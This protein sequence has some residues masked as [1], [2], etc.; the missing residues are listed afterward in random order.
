MVILSTGDM[1]D[2]KVASLLADYDRD[3]ITNL[4]QPIIG[5][6]AL[7]V[8]FTFWSEAK[9]QRVISMSSHE[10]LLVRMKIATGEF[11]D[12]RKALEAVG[13]L[14]TRLEK[15]NG[16][17]IYHYELIPPK[18]PN[19]FFNDTL[20]YG[21][22]IQYLG[23]NEANRIKR[24]YETQEVSQV[25]D[26]ISSSFNDVF[27]P[28]F[29][30]AAFLLASTKV[31]KTIG[32]KKSKIDTEFSYEKFFASLAEVSQINQNALTKAEI[33]EIERLSTLYGVSEE[34]AAEKAANCYI[35]EN[36]KGKRLDVEQFNKDLRNEINYGLRNVKKTSKG[37]NN[38]F[39]EDGLAAKVKLYETASPEK[40]LSLLQNGTKPASADLNIIRSLAEDYHLENPVISVIIDFALQMNNNVLSKYSVEKIA[41]SVSREGIETAIDA[42]DYLNKNYASKRNKKNYNSKQTSVSLE[43]KTESSDNNSSEMSEEDI[44]ELLSIFSN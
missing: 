33:K 5:H 15:V 25:G 34:V 19:K 3:T 31:D 16:F 20:L 44:D 4:Y 32:R 26:D 7:A 40:V 23:E 21:L 38:V 10:Q 43:N 6:T 8:Y 18:Y 22:L 28:D 39:G 37:K 9:N 41:S 42:M 24:V 29:E 30:D 14:K 17:S 35:A 36:A 11:V 1:F 27:H 12:A 13:L 2:I